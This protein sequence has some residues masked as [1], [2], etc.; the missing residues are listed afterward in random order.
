MANF[1]SGSTRKSQAVG[2]GDWK[3]E[4]D[5][6]KFGETMEKIHGP[7]E[8]RREKALE[9]AREKVRERKERHHG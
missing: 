7:E 1:G 5:E 3:R 8:E 2:K 6:E 9:R 4:V